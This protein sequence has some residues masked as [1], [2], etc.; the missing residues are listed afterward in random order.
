MKK[1]KI[2]VIN[3]AES[4]ERLDAFARQFASLDQEFEKVEAVPGGGLSE[5]E[6]GQYYHFEQSDYYK[7]LNLGEIGCYLS[8]FKVWQM[9]IEQELDYAIVLEDDVLL[10]EHFLPTLDK[11]QTLDMPWDIIK[12][13]E[14]PIK[15]KVVRE[16]SHDDASLVVYNKVPKGTYAQVISASGAKKLFSEKGQKQAYCIQRPIDI[17]IQYWWEKDL[18]VYGLKPYSVEID[19][20]HPSE[21]DEKALRQ[22]AKKSFWRQVH[23]RFY[24]LFK[25]KKELKKRLQKLD[26]K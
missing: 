19:N 16:I 3:L 20:S 25:N 8:H 24:F 15:R 17:D 6:A 1:W 5:D 13:A 2:F 22:R 9:I 10:N 18:E 26:S 14:F 21:I 12:L 4:T 23:S 7:E 11:L